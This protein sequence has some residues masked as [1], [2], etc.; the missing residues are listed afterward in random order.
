MIVLVVLSFWLFLV[1][2]VIL[3]FLVAFLVVCCFVLI[4]CFGRRIV[5]VSL[6]YQVFFI[7]STRETHLLP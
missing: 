4:G 1:V 7:S 2:L 5:W 6:V 3:S